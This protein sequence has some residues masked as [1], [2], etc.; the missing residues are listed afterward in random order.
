MAKTPTTQRSA[1][2]AVP[3]AKTPNELMRK[4]EDVTL[5]SKLALLIRLCE[6]QAAYEPGGVE[7]QLDSLFWTGLEDLARDMLS[8]VEELQSVAGVKTEGF[9]T[10]PDKGG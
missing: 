2:A 6:A 5:P 3:L 8:E 4:L 9:A 1:L 10:L 7:Q